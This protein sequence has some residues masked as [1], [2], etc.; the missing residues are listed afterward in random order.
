MDK[1]LLQ[2][3]RKTVIVNK[4]L[5]FPTSDLSMYHPMTPNPND[6]M[7]TGIHRYS[8]LGISS[9][10]NFKCLPFS[11]YVQ[12]PFKVS[13]QNIVFVMAFPSCP[14]LRSVLLVQFIDRLVVK[15]HGQNT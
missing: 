15:P 3:I 14:I 5:N 9:D 8:L 13:I 2:G 4:E 1:I 12:R 7:S 11:Q 6:A 10:G